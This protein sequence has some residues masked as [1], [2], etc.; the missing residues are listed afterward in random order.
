M[1]VF[2]IGFKDPA[3]VSFL[4]SNGRECQEKYSKDVNI[5]V[6]KSATYKRETKAYKQAKKD[7]KP[8]MPRDEFIA[9]YAPEYVDLGKHLSFTDVPYPNGLK[10]KFHGSKDISL[11]S[12][13]NNKDYVLYRGE[14]TQKL[15]DDMHLAL[16]GKEVLD[17]FDP[18]RS[19]MYVP[20]KDVFYSLVN[21]PSL[22][23]KLVSFKFNKKIKDVKVSVLAKSV[24]AKDLRS[25]FLAL[26]T[27]QIKK[28]KAIQLA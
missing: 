5:V 8:I 23:V 14:Y 13:I 26:T 17:D 6:I 10:M 4:T 2:F 21:F 3:L 15:L 1:K 25:A 11:A 7:R 18:K 22:E 27:D 16:L 28:T 9:K 24:A 20:A 19:L 12:L